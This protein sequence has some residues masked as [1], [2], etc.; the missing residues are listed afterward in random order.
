M[1]LGK[2]LEINNA[3]PEMVGIDS[4]VRSGLRFI[5]NGWKY[6]VGRWELT[7]PLSGEAN[8]EVARSN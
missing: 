8:S 1:V 5:E 3:T 2:K 4:R 6:A 7:V